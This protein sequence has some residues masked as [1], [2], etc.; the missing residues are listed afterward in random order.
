MRKWLVIAFIASISFLLAGCPRADYSTCSS[1]PATFPGGKCSAR[2]YQSNFGPGNATTQATTEC[3]IG[4][5]QLGGN[6]VAFDSIDHGIGLRWLDANTLEVS[7]PDG[8]KLEDQRQRDAYLGYRLTYK[9]RSLLPTD[10]A[11]SGC[12]P[13]RPKSST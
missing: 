5:Q 2:Y 1:Q 3:K 6:I 9:Y 4:A 12:H 13:K 11:F 7:V 10:S 8:A